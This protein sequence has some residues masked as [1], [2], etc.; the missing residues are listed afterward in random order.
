MTDFSGSEFNSAPA[1][2]DSLQSINC[3]HFG[4][5]LPVTK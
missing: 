1:T 3:S 2:N 5:H 4:F